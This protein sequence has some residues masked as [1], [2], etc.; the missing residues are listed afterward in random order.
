MGNG[1]PERVTLNSVTGEGAPAVK[2]S[3]KVLVDAYRA[4]H[5]NDLAANAEHV[6]A[7]NYPADSK[8]ILP[9]KHWWAI[10]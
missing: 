8:D 6:Y 4:L 1:E 10:F 3:L 5:M 2:G 9:K 7:N